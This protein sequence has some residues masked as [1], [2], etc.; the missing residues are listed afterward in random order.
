[1][2]MK[3]GPLIVLASIIGAATLAGLAQVYDR[4]D[5]Q[6]QYGQPQSAQPQY[7]QQQYGQPQYGQPQYQEGYG[8]QGYGQGGYDQSRGD[9]GRWRH[10]RAGVYPQ[11]RAIERH[12][13]NEI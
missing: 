7:G 11:F 6:Q 3:H 4:D 9:F 10:G 5:S 13:A 1:M 8:E 2:K 12:I